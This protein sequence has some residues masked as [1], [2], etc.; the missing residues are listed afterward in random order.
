MLH[1]VHHLNLTVGEIAGAT[2]VIVTG[3]PGR[4]ERIARSEAFSNPRFVAQNREYCTWLATAHDRPVL[5]TST[6]IGGP[7]LAIA[8]EELATLG[9]KTF[10]RVGTCGAIQP[11]IHVGDVVITTGGV[12]LEG[13]SSHY[14]PLEYP[15]VADPEVLFALM[16]S[17]KALNRVHH[18]GIT[19]SS[20][21]FYPGQERF[22][23]YSKYV[24]RRFQGITEE[25]RQL[26]VL[27]YEMEAAT[28]LAVCSVFGLRAGC[29]CGAVVNRTRSEQI[30]TELVA[31]A[32]GNAIQVA[33][34]AMASLCV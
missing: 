9:V 19:C 15:A 33:T 26:H 2:S 4:V 31:T 7:S 12:R 18:V 13:T 16:H 6:G 23:T 1:R 27:N 5:V 8:V 3:D 21:T 11:Q 34:H 17:A 30:N 25:W 29:V 10:L 14:A 24:P 22:D 32:E 28:L 20:D